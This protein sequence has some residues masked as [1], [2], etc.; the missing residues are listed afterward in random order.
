MTEICVIGLDCSTTAT[1]AI[2]WDVNGVPLAEGRADLPLSR[3]GRGLY[4]QEPEQW[5]A[6]LCQ[7]TRAAVAGLRHQVVAV[8]VANQRE[9]VGVLDAGMRSVRP[10]M[11]WCDERGR[12]QVARVA[13]ELGAR[14][15]HDRTGKPVE[16]CPALYRMLW[17]RDVEPAS[18]ARASHFVDVQGY[19]NWHLTGQLVTSWASADPFGLLDMRRFSWDEEL[20]GELALEPAL[21][22]PLVAPGTPVGRVTPEA[23]A[24]CGLPAGALVVAGGGDGQAAGLGARA[25]SAGRAYCN[26]G[27]A[28]VAGVGTQQYRAD[29]AFR[30]LTSCVPGGSV[31]EA[32]LRAGTS[33]VSWFVRQFGAPEPLAAGR[34]AEEA[35]EAVALLVP[36]GSDGL[37]VLPHWN[38]AGTPHWDGDARGAVVGWTPI[39]SRAHFYR[40][41]LEGVA[42]ELRQAL[43]GIAEVTGEPITHL[44]VTGG[45]A[46]SA[47]WRQIIA[48]VTGRAVV[49]VASTELTSLGAGMLAAAGVGAFPD[50]AA[51]ALAMT[52]DV[53]TIT[54]VPATWELYDALYTRAYR[55]LYPALREV[56]HALSALE[57]EGRWAA[58]PM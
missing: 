45:G 50:V 47:L 22:S 48:D 52:R 6:A 56:T 35:L 7:A 13:A 31:C 21:F 39:H 8:A 32:L 3:P 9:T 42:M 44:V 2:V 15:V 34:S 1:K 28:A 43:D 37:I 11:L 25:L 30:T 29:L 40:A 16:L 38:A 53:A 12:A 23:A 33:L 20:M 46:R 19:L 57:Q 41:V 58:P 26:L 10:A 14:R 36:A 17:L 54:P 18:F 55:P 49:L 4:E 27:T 24:A 5:W 51:A